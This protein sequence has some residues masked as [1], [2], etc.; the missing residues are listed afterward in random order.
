MPAINRAGFLT[1]LAG[2]LL[3]TFILGVGGR[4]AMHA[5]VRIG[6]GTGGFTLGGRRLSSGLAPPPASR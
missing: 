5:I 6:G 2:A 4:L 1:I 3:G